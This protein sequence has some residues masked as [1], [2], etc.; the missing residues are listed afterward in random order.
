M[1][2]EDFSSVGVVSVAVMMTVVLLLLLLVVVVVVGPLNARPAL[3]PAEPLVDAHRDLLRE[4]VHVRVA[5]E[6]VHCPAQGGAVQEGD[7]G[8]IV[9]AELRV[10]L[11]GRVDFV[12][13]GRGDEECELVRDPE[14]DGADFGDELGR[15]GWGVLSAETVGQRAGGL[16]GAV[17]C[18]AGGK[19]LD[20]CAQED[21]LG[22]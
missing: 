3:E 9:D 20:G 4:R 5:E 7:G 11:V 6:R 10:D 2:D 1:E 12:G 19:G 14:S 15:G 17:G 16:D 22:P 13:Q 8:L 21:P 18:T